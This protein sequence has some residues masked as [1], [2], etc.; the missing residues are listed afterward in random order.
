MRYI[1]KTINNTYY[2]INSKC[3]SQLCSDLFAS[4]MTRTEHQRVV[5]TRAAPEYSDNL[6]K[7]CKFEILFRLSFYFQKLITVP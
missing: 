3:R 1:F 4:V 6:F 2:C 5:R 7:L